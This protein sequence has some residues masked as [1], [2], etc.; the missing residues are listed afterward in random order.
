MLIIVGIVLIIALVISGVI[1]YVMAKQAKENKITNEK[2]IQILQK[3]TRDSEKAAIVTPEPVITPI[4]NSITPTDFMADWKTYSNSLYKYSFKY[5]NLGFTITEFTGKPQPPV[6]DFASLSEDKYRNSYE[7]PGF[8]S[9]TIFQNETD[10]GLK[11]WITQS[12]AKGLDYLSG[13]KAYKV[14]NK[15]GYSFLSSGIV[16]Y[17]SYAAEIDSTHI[18]VIETTDSTDLFF[19]VLSTFLFQ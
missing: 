7:Y 16:N 1:W 9:I 17:N 5:P 8:F 12:N 19:N 11:K 18:A 10:L 6:V 14:G 3:Q 2:Q 15:D 13:I 4:A